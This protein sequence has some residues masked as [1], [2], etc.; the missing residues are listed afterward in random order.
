MTYA[1]V[2]EDDFPERSRKRLYK[3][4]FMAPGPKV[5]IEERG[6]IFDP[7]NL[8]IET[9][10]DF[11]RVGEPRPDRYYESSNVLGILYRSIDESSFFSDLRKRSAILRDDENVTKGVLVDLW[12]YVQA[13]TS[14]LEWEHYVEQAWRIR[15]A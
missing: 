13:E 8:N 11:R 5:K 7:E 9:P 3:P 14:E 6:I 10:N 1:Q 15:Y 2:T 12:D 4:D